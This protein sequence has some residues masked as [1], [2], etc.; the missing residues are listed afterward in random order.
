M[1]FSAPGIVGA[2]GLAAADLAA[3]MSAHAGAPEQFPGELEPFPQ[4]GVTFQYNAG[5]V[6]DDGL[7]LRVNIYRPSASGEYPVIITHGIYGKDLAWQSAEP[8]KP[9]WKKVNAQLPGLC[10]ESTCAFMRW[11]MP[12]PERWVPAGYVVI[13]ADA[14]GLGKTPGYLDP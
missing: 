2:A 7:P 5:V 10:K 4:P 3:C 9:T 11:E 8:R 1:K 13:Q 14:R 12:D 6:M